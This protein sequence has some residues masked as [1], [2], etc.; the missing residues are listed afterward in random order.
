MNSN[1]ITNLPQEKSNYPSIDG[2]DKLIRAIKLAVQAQEYSTILVKFNYLSLWTTILQQLKTIDS[3]LAI[4]P[5]V[6]DKETKTL[7]QGI[8]EELKDDQPSALM[9]FGMESVSD[10]D[11]VLRSTKQ[12]REKISHEFSCPLVLWLTDDMLS[13]LVRLSPDFASPVSVPIEID[14]S[15]DEVTHLINSHAEQIFRMVIKFGAGIFGVKILQETMLSNQNN[16]LSNQNNDWLTFSELNF[17]KQDL[18]KCGVTL[19][20]ELKAN[21]EFLLGY[22]LNNLSGSNIM[23]LRYCDEDIS[24]NKFCRKQYEESLELYRKTDNFKYQA[25]VLYCLGLWWW[26]YGMSYRI[27]RDKA[28]I[29]VKNYWQECVKLFRET[30]DQALEAR[31]INAEAEALKRVHDWEQLKT[32]GQRAKQLHKKYHN[33]LRLA[34]IN[35]FLAEVAFYQ[36]KNWKQAKSLAEEAYNSVTEILQNPPDD[37]PQGWLEWTQHYHQG[38]YLLPLAKA[39]YQ[40][41]ESSEAIQHLEKAK[42]E[43]KPDYDPELYIS[44]LEELQKIYYQKGEHKTAFSVKQKQ[45]KIE[46]QFGFRAFIG[47][48]PLPTKHIIN[49]PFLL[50]LKPETV[51]TSVIG[52]SDRSNKM[53][54][55]ITCITSTQHKLIVV[56]GGSGVG[57]SSLFRAKLIPVL[58]QIKNIYPRPVL[59]ILISQYPNWFDDIGNYLKKE[60]DDFQVV[61]SD[62]SINKIKKILEQLRKNNNDNILTVLIFDNLEELCFSLQNPINRPKLAN[63]SQE[64]AN[65]IQE[66]LTIPFVKIILSVREDYLYYLLN[67]SRLANFD[68]INNNILDK[69]NLY[70]IGYL[71]LDEAKA[72]ILELTQNT[73]LLEESLL[74]R[75]VNDLATPE[76]KVIPI[77]LQMVGT[78]LENNKI[79][80][81]QDYE[82]LTQGVN[83]KK[84]KKILLDQ[85][86]EE[87]TKDC[88]IENQVIAEVV[89]YCLTDS[90]NIRPKQTYDEL[91]DKLELSELES[92]EQQLDVVLAISTESGLVQKPSFFS[93]HRCF[94][95]QLAPDHLTQIIQKRF[96]QKYHQLASNLDRKR[97]DVLQELA[98]KEIKQ[99]NLTAQ[100][101]FAEHDQLKALQA[102][103]ESSE[104][105]KT[106]KNLPLEVQQETEKTIKD[107]IYG[108]EEYNHFEEHQSDVY[109]VNFSRKGSFT[110]DGR[111]LASASWDKT[112]EIWDVENDEF[113][114]NVK[115]HQ[116]AVNSVKISPDGKL[117]ASASADQTIKVWLISW[118]STKQ[119]FTCEEWKKDTLSHDDWVW[120][121]CFSSD[122]K[123]LASAGGDRL[124]KL[125]QLNWSEKYQDLTIKHFANLKGHDDKVYTIDFSPDNQT[126]ASGSGE[127][128]N[129]IKLWDINTKK[130]KETLAEQQRPIK[131]VRFSHSGEYLAS[132]SEDGTIQLW[133]IKENKVKPYLN[134]NHKEQVNSVSFREDDQVLASGG[135]DNTVKLWSLEGD[136]LKTFRGHRDWVRYV[137]FSPNG[138]IL[139]S[140]SDDNTI[141]LRKLDFI[142]PQNLKGHGGKIHS[143]CFSRDGNTLA[144]GGWDG[145]IRLWSRETDNIWKET[146]CILDTDQKNQPNWVWEVSFSP[147]G[148]K[149]VSGGGDNR[150]KLWNLNQE[151]PQILEE[152][153]GTVHTVRFSPNGN[154]IASGSGDRSVKLWNGDT[155]KLVVTC[156]EQ[157]NNQHTDK[158]WGVAFS[159]DGQTLASAS[160][161]NTIKHWDLN[162]KLIR[163]IGSY[164][165]ND[166]PEGHQDWINGVAFNPDSKM[167]ASASNDN[168]IKLWN[169]SNGKCLNTLAKHNSKVYDVGFS[170]DG[171]FLISASADKTL[172]IWSIDGTLLRTLEG[173]SDWVNSA[174]FSPNGQFIASASNDKTIKIWDLS[175]IKLKVLTPEELLDKGHE[176]LQ[177]YEKSQKN[178]GSLR[179]KFHS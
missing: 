130:C 146:K 134:L 132:A 78:Q 20:D 13:K 52:Q 72:D 33:D 116:D 156:G 16:E 124:I 95:Y 150:I 53:N 59:P 117:L 91:K 12:D 27:E 122:G 44:I 92:T 136:L 21:L 60:I 152:H 172:K 178:Q 158:V 112:I 154:Y 94:T 115:G 139:A 45:R 48:I 24:V 175:N 22:S 149:L 57:K 58:K 30:G 118:N 23:S 102:S 129:T 125:W 109:S 25:C 169:L 86:L 163:T 160:A 166:H 138:K 7:Y 18:E 168:T 80:T 114:K 173:H 77:E 73:Y 93:D 66:S 47:L 70:Y 38:W 67:L 123:M 155:G 157:M 101:S 121:V 89:L 2:L 82:K 10:V 15:T 43:T 63:Y 46:Q 83:E 126:L 31:F 98:I 104:K 11:Q 34:R 69:N 137:E 54:Q 145:T 40:L 4:H 6:L 142:L 113:V 68:I 5:I 153:T 141:K 147:D 19:N 106:L 39:E 143:I 127:K 49:N 41:Q 51:E 65:F 50:P 161:D 71:E 8:K 85:Y 100:K 167:L 84:P 55:L 144:S 176:W 97:S 61:A 110:P 79:T 103:L 42:K 174:M 90:N 76:G 56:Y 148:Q 131:S 36:N 99:L 26:G 14:I 107:I 170:P 64:F 119:E 140:A 29:K 35:G 162:G 151:S 75:L 62:S 81:L 164:E 105:L 120:D 96:R 159:P 37:F 87:I 9:V 88:G 74:D 108:L 179:Q 177:H 28:F 111:F 128:D 1:L 133:E 17:A 32:I 171:Q 165:Q 3:S 135:N